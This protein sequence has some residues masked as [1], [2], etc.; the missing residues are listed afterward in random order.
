MNTNT[1]L[2][3][4]LAVLGGLVAGMLFGGSGLGL[5][6]L[7]LGPLSPAYM[8]ARSVDQAPA[9]APAEPYVQ[10]YGDVDQTRRS[11]DDGSVSSGCGGGVPEDYPPTARPGYGYPYGMMGY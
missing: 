10:P 8:M 6:G 1:N 11:Y 5:R 7:V 3:I 2:K 9:Y 4:A